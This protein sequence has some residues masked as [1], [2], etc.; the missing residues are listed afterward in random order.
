MNISL[1]MMTILLEKACSFNEGLGCWVDPY[2][3]NSLSKLYP[4]A[5]PQFMHLQ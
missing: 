2:Y 4:V 1:F 5:L 3:I